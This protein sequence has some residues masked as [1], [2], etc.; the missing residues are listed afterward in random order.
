MS[1]QLYDVEIEDTEVEDVVPP[2]CDADE[3]IKILEANFVEVVEF[4]EDE[5][6]DPPAP[7]LRF[8]DCPPLALAG[9]LCA[10]ISFAGVVL[11]GGFVAALLLRLT[12]LR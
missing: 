7:L 4:E 1:L 5:P 8:G 10:M 2:D 6:Q 12:G 11:Y 9:I 3:L